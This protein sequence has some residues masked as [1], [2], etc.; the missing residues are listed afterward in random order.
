[1]RPTPEGFRHCTPLLLRVDDID[2]MNHLN[3]A[4]YLSLM[5]DA[6]FLY[7]RDLDLWDGNP[8]KPG[9]IVA[10]ALVDYRVPVVFGDQI[11]LYTRCSRLGT[12]SM[13]IGHSVVRFHQDTLQ[14]VASGVI[15]VVVM[16]FSSNQSMPI[17]GMWRE[18]ILAYE[19]VA[20]AQK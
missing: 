13:D 20:P 1:M 6:R 4:K 8:G 14:E 18:K 19:S 3:N 15:T 9:I 2:A 16:N 17:P 12:K 11:A 7:F 5:N 10:R